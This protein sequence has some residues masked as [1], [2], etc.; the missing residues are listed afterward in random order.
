MG[1]K[2]NLNPAIFMLFLWEKKGKIILSPPWVKT[3][4]PRRKNTYKL[5][6]KQI[7][8]LFIYVNIIFFYTYIVYVCKSKRDIILQSLVYSQD[9][10]FPFVTGKRIFFL[11]YF[12]TFLLYQNFFILFPWASVFFFSSFLFHFILFFPLLLFSRSLI[13][14]V[15]TSL[16]YLCFFF[17]LSPS[18]L[19]V[20]AHRNILLCQLVNIRCSFFYKRARGCSHSLKSEKH[21]NEMKEYLL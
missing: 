1:K 20:G 9:F 13:S 14:A 11:F 19:L 5:L 21:D 6:Q 10:R 3:I 15:L 4:S 7:D 2:K 12:F 18:L 17:S 8:Y 16:L